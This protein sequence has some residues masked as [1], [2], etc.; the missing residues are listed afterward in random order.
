MSIDRW[1]DKEVVVHIYNRMLFSH[2]KEQIWVSS[3]E[4][5]E[6]RAY[7]TESST[8][9]NC[10]NSCPSSRWCQPIISPSVIPFS[11]CLQSFPTSGSFLTRRLFAS[12]G[13]SI[14]VSTSA[15][16]LPINIQGWFPLGLTDLI[17]LQSKGLSRVFSITT[18]QKQQFCSSAFFM[19]QLSHSYTTIGKTIALTRQIFVGKVMSLLF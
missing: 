19:V 12:G 2:E 9:G 8:P 7:Y 1:M 4:V 15:S 3:S 17:S 11:S 10:S 5:D 6:P 16:V 18:V 14:G 13:Q